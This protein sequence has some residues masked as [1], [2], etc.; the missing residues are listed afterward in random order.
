M[1]GF[2]LS[3]KSAFYATADAVAIPVAYDAKDLL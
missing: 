2:H 1:S 3:E